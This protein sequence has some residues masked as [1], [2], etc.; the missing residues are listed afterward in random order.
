MSRGAWGAMVGVVL[1]PLLYL[2][3]WPA[4]IEPVA[5]YPDAPPAAEGV[6]APNEL[7]RSLERMSLGGA[8]A[9]EDVAV[10]GRGRVYTGVEDGRILRFDPGSTSPVEH[11]NTG[12]RPLGLEIGLDGGLVVADAEKGLVLIDP[13]GRVEEVDVEAEGERLAFADDVEVGPDNVAYVT[14]ASWKFNIHNWELDIL[15]SRP[16][17]R[18]V[19]VDLETL[20]GRQV[21]ED[22]FFPNGVALD[23]Q[24]RFALVC[25]SSRYRVVR[26][27]LGDRFGEADVF[28][29]NLPGF[30]DG[31]TGD[32][33]G[34]YWVA[35]AAPRNGTVDALAPWPLLRKVITRL[36]SSVRPEAARAGMVLR[37][38]GE[39]R[40]V[41]QRADPGGAAM[42]MI[43]SAEPYG[44]WL[45]LGSLGEG[46]IARVNIGAP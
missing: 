17:G 2:L 7:L 43:T 35:I 26:I 5:W 22:L 9:G 25:E 14:D 38:D 36:P 28:A 15:E 23:P 32:D 29:A 30:P 6:L 37:L 39:G 24:G 40:V 41:E 8:R 20:R 3:T 19:A 34:S 16:N 10:D 42:G 1:G 31:I 44:E 33:R 46:F 21:R 18:L 13:E 12:G 27:W 45:Y 11:A 4:P